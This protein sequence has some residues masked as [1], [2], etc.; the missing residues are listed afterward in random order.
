MKEKEYLADVL[1]DS[2]G[3]KQKAAKSLRI[4]LATLYRKLPET[5]E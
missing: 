1:K 3:D 2:D 5:Q 4:S